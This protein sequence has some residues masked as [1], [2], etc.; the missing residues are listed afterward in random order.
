MLKHRFAEKSLAIETVLL[1]GIE[2]AGA[3]NAAHAKGLV[4]RDIKAANIFVT[5]QG[6]A[7]ILGRALSWATKLLPSRTSV[8]GSVITR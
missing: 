4:H 5:E 1:L 8:N 6:H 3:L 2:I 7:E